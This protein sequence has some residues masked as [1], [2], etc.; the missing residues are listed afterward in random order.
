MNWSVCSKDSEVS[1]CDLPLV[2]LRY[3][4][5]GLDLNFLLKAKL[6]SCVC[7]SCAYVCAY[8]YVCFITFSPCI[9]E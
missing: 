1:A 3:S 6:M 8:V 4:K 5:R 2:K 9:V 7:V